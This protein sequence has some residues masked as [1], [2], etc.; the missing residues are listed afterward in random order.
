MSEGATEERFPLARIKTRRRAEH[1]ARRG[2]PGQVVE[3]VGRRVR[4]RDEAGERVCYL[5]GER[6][7]IGDRVLWEEAPGTGGKLLGV[8]ERETCLMRRDNQGHER[9]LAAN[10][11]GLVVVAS[12]VRPA[13]NASLVDRYLVAA[14]AAGLDMAICL[15]KCDL[16]VTEEIAGDL[17]LRRELGFR[18]LQTS[19]KLEGGLDELRDFLAEVSTPERGPWALMGLSGV[20]KTSLVQ[21]LLPEQDVG[22]IGEVSE[23]WEQGRH[24]T[25]RSWFFALPGGGEICD[26]PGI[27][28]FSPAG[29]TLE[30]V[31]DFYPGMGD[32]DCQFRDCL[33]REGQK[34]CVAE[35]EVNERILKGYRRLLA[36]V[37]NQRE[38]WA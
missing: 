5:S 6:A 10:L 12:P 38:S 8:L 25:T 3:T 24:T 23:H 1:A 19:T 33:H 37:D 35:S 18:V 34:G 28:T 20:G 14:G 32:L 2:K 9:I 17:A 30:Q 7:V 16:E 29:L 26:S 27:R 4:V 22:P 13:F 36:W 31:R 21:A 15:N 11:A